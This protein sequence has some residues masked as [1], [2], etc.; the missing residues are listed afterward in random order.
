[1]V[2]RNRWNTMK[3]ASST[4]H[5]MRTELTKMKAIKTSMGAAISTL[6]LVGTLALYKKIESQIDPT[7]TE[8]LTIVE[9][10]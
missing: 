7:D 3:H 9:Y 5:F 4:G 10:R 8:N 6:G 1:M 2:G